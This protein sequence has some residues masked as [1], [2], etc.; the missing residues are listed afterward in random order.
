MVGVQN[1]KNEWIPEVEHKPKEGLKFRSYHEAYVFYKDYA[2]IAEFEVRK[3][4]SIKMA[5]GV[6]Y[7]HK[8]VVCA[9]A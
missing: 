4:T 9:K 5:S 7:S 8:Y 3:T 2:K 6:G 1:K